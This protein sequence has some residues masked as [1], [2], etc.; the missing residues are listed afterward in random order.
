AALDD[1]VGDAPEAVT[2]RSGVDVAFDVVE[3][4]EDEDRLTGGVDLLARRLAAG[5]RAAAVEGAPVA[6][7]PPSPG[8]PQRATPAVLSALGVP[9]LHGP[10][11]R[12]R[13]VRHAV[14]GGGDDALV[15]HRAG[16][17]VVLGVG[18]EQLERA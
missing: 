2:L 15:P 17:A 1:A 8:Q 4:V 16:H 5:D 18:L 3:A 13:D 10:D 7:D 11:G 14:N 12:N 6:G 9:E